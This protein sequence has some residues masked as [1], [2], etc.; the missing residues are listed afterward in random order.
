MTFLMDAAQQTFVSSTYWTEA[1]GPTA[2]VA[3][4]VRME[5]VNVSRH[6]G[7]IGTL[8]RAG[9][10]AAG[11]RHGLPVKVG[12]IPALCVLSFDAGETSRA[13]MT[14]FTQEMLARG[15]LAAGAFYPTYAHKPDV[16]E[17]CL[18]AVDA[19]FAILKK[20]IDD[21][22]VVAALHGPVAQSGFARL[23]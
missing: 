5:A 8:V 2:A 4:L 14:L 13:L 9:W 10:A 3:T 23:T 15:F 6:I 17:K 12:G 7:E 18:Q 1:I 21:G 19:A 11:T 20:N 22:T 16:V